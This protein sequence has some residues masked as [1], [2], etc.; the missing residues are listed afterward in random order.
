MSK[1]KADAASSIRAA[2]TTAGSASG[3]LPRTFHTPESTTFR[4][5]KETPT[6]HEADN[7]FPIVGNDGQPISHS[8]TPHEEQQQHIKPAAL[9]APTSGE[10]SVDEAHSRPWAMS[11][12]SFAP[13]SSGNTSQVELLPGERDEENQDHPTQP[14]EQPPNWREVKGK[15]ERYFKINSAGAQV[16][17]T[18]LLVAL[19]TLINPLEDRFP[20]N[21]VYIVIATVIVA[22]PNQTISVRLYTQ[23]LI[24]VVVAGVLSLAVLGLDALVAPRYCLDCSYKPYAVGFILFFFIYCS[25]SLRESIPGQAYT[26]KLTDMTFVITLLGAYDDLRKNPESQRYA[27]PLA[28]MASMVVGLLLTMIGASIFWPVRVNLV[29]RIETGNLFKEMASYFHDLIH[30]GYLKDP[31]Q[32]PHLSD[33]RRMSAQWGGTVE[34]IAVGGGMDVIGSEEAAA[35]PRLTLDRTQKVRTRSAMGWVFGDVPPPAAS[36]PPTPPPS[37]TPP[38]G[39]RDTHSPV[40]IDMPVS[41]APVDNPTLWQQMFEDALDKGHSDSDGPDIVKTFHEKTHPAAVHIIRTLEK[42]R[43]RLEASY[44]VEVRWTQRPHFIPIA[45]L[46]QVIRRLRLLYY[47]LS[48]LYS[49]RLITLRALSPRFL[50]SAHLATN[51]SMSEW[52]T[53]WMSDAV[54]LM[55]V[56][57]SSSTDPALFSMER[58][59]STLCKALIDLGDVVLWTTSQGQRIIGSAELAARLE[60]TVEEVL[61]KRD[62]LE[63]ELLRIR[64]QL[65]ES[66][67]AASPASSSSPPASSSLPTHPVQ[68]Y[69]TDLTNDPHYNDF[70]SSSSTTAHV[71]R[72]SRNRVFGSPPIPAPHPHS[73][74]HDRHHGAAGALTADRPPD[75]YLETRAILAFQYATYVRLWEITE[76]VLSAA[77]AVGKLIKV[78]S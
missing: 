78:Y 12:V 24:G 33:H 7:Y 8:R 53:T 70:P 18:V 30:E 52:V 13:H 44:Q 26:S 43:A 49:D 15:L 5:P 28:R 38:S 17:F 2:A 37:S 74:S 69:Q 62:A 32:I 45:P 41:G 47:Q 71:R 68:P 61:E 1:L 21:T 50:E 11:A 42:E 60:V 64:K 19:F 39:S 4:T 56:I 76:V 6:A 3:S 16:A 40:V 35:A 59:T 54:A 48:G 63:E 23:R 22:S 14:H 25:V 27:P 36:A 10:Y 75:P 31:S 46:T 20:T 72:S 55:H 77:R 67:S 34:S 58:Y 65:L 51:S 29:H 66:D 9:R 57:N 73:L